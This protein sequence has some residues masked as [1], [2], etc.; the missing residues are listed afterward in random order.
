MRVFPNPDEL[1]TVFRDLSTE[2]WFFYKFNTGSACRIC[3]AKKSDFIQIDSPVD[4]SVLHLDKDVV[5]D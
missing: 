5:L 3:G 1:S 4:E 2:K